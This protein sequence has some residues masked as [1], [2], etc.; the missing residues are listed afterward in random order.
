MRKRLQPDEVTSA[1]ESLPEWSVED[2]KLRREY[3]FSDFTV[4]FGFMAA[5]AT[6]AE[7]LDHHPDWSNVY[8]RVSVTLWTH[9]EGGL[10][11]LDFELARRMEAL[12]TRWLS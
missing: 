3:R 9:S 8:G 10:T 6:V 2:G 7:R 5:A 12:A 1:S 11:A 4:A